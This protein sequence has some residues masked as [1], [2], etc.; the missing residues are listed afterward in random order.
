MFSKLDLQGGFHQLRIQEGGD[1]QK[2]ASVTPG[3]QVRMGHVPFRA[4]QHA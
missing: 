4:L 3:G 2:T 1:Q